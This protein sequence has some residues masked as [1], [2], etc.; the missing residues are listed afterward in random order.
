MGLGE[1]TILSS[2][3]LTITPG[4]K[5]TAE[6]QSLEA[7]KINIA[8]TA[9]GL[10]T[11]KAAYGSGGS[12]SL[13]DDDGKSGDYAKFSIDANGDISTVQ[14]F[15]IGISGPAGTF[16]AGETITGTTSSATGI[17]IS[18]N[19]ANM[20]LKTIS[21]TFTNG[22]ELTGGTSGATT[23]TTSSNNAIEHLKFI[24]QS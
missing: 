10:D 4:D 12:Y 18:D 24:D 13:E 23:T 3:T 9:K 14:T 11:Y 7:T 20:I 19:G 15:D 21:G 17:Y 5:A 2:V 22:E 6:Y 16:R 1:I 8:N